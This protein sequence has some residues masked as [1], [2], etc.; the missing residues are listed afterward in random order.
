[1]IAIFIALVAMAGPVEDGAALW[2]G[3]D[4]DGAITA[5]ELALDAGPGSAV[6][7]SNLGVANYRKGDLPKAIAHWRQ[8]KVLAP[9]WG[10]PTHNLAVA[11]AELE[12][13]PRPVD[14][15]APW[16]GLATV[17]ELGVLGTVFFLG[18]SI[19][20]W[21]AWMR[22]WS[23]WPAVAVASIG[24][25]FAG[26]SV[27]GLRRLHRHP[28]AVVVDAGVSLRPEPDV[29]APARRTLAPGSEVA[30]ERVVGDYLLVVASDDQRGF[31]PRASVAVVG[32]RLERPGP[33]G[34]SHVL[35]ER[36]TD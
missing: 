34:A 18:S 5:W 14:P 23:L 29:S 19:W 1:M 26:M 15:L 27:E 28:G 36:P 25:V 22:R 12:G 20:G 30:V 33:H 10:D 13:A 9:R 11:R 2:D 17:G 35:G 4:M 21:L 3:G 8:A 7:H 6:L 31:V 32:A 24:L 16:L